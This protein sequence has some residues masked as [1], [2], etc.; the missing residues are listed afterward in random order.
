MSEKSGSFDLVG[1]MMHGSI[2]ILRPRSAGK[3]IPNAS[4]W[5][6]H[7]FPANY[8]VDISQEIETK[9]EA[10]AAY[11]NELQ[12]FPHPCSREGLRLLSK[13]HGMQCGC[14]ARRS[15]PFHPSDG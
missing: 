13:Y 6:G 10:F 7:I 2:S 12:S 8:Y 3:D 11:R 14:P 1:W 5:N 15:L 4:F 9:I